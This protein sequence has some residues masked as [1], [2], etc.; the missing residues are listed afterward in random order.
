M[1]GGSSEER[2]SRHW[3]DFKSGS[4]LLSVPKK[5]ASN[6]SMK[7]EPGNVIESIPVLIRGFAP[8]PSSFRATGTSGPLRS[9]NEM[10]SDEDFTTFA[11]RLSHE[12]AA[13]T[14]V[15]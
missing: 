11:R 1:A 7:Q 3:R 9:S 15:L 12:V 10:T 6:T 2:P 14:A 4:H 8:S 13:C 5:S